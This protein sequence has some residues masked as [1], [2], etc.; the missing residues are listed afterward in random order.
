MIKGP[1]GRLS[2]RI[3]TSGAVANGKLRTFCKGKGSGKQKCKIPYFFNGSQ[4]IEI[5]RDKK[6]IRRIHGN[7]SGGSMECHGSRDK[8]DFRVC[9]F[10]NL[11]YFNKTFYIDT[12]YTVDFECPIVMPNGRSNPVAPW[13]SQVCV[14]KL[15]ATLKNSVFYSG[16]YMYTDPGFFTYSLW[17]GFVEQ[18]VPVWQGWVT[19]MGRDPDT[20]L[21]TDSSLVKDYRNDTDLF[22]NTKPQALRDGTTYEEFF[23]G[24]A[25]IMDDKAHIKPE[26]KNYKPYDM[27][28]Y[29]NFTEFVNVREFKQMFYDHY[30]TRDLPQEKPLVLFVERKQKRRIVNQKTA[31]EALRNEFP[32]VNICLIEPEK[33]SMGEQVELFKAADVLIAAHGMALT[34]SI[35][36]NESKSVIEI[37]PYM[38]S[39]RDWYEQWA[40]AN[41]LH[42]QYFVPSE[43]PFKE[44]TEKDQRLKE[45]YKI[46]GCK[47]D[48]LDKTLF[49]NAWVDIPTLI[50]MTRKALLDAGVKLE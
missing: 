38:M 29:F 42:Y 22:L 19:Y 41:K 27:Y 45:C 13:R 36:M 12:P 5:V 23:A 26:R 6:V 18:T 3:K 47:Y 24:T 17:H 49:A 1:P 44:E 43:D 50:N 16:R 32:Q 31:A 4:Y 28:E 25:K 35:W 14:K 8:W 34:Q 15:P 9:R 21:V 33:Y 30:K 10:K 39:C 48:C 11:T 7:T 40:Y 20:I 2:W 37:F 46:D